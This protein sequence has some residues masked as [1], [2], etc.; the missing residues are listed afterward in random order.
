M[1]ENRFPEH[2]R[3]MT[4]IYDCGRGVV[5]KTLTA[6]RE[7]EMDSIVTFLMETERGGVTIIVAGVR[8]E[9]WEGSE[10]KVMAVTG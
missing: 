1:C 2:Q 4:R 3:G 5:Q 10:G 8:K 6:K 7:G 9:L